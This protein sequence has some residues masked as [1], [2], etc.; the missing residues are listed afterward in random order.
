MSRKPSYAQLEQRLEKLEKERSMRSL[1]EKALG[2]N[3]KIVASAAIGI[4][5]YESSGECILANEMAAEFIGGTKEKLLRQNFR[6]I[7]SWKKTGLYDLAIETLSTGIT[8]TTEIT[9]T[10]TFGKK[11]SLHCRFGF[12]RRAP[13]LV[14]GF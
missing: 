8:R 13:G 9:T 10:S 6:H 12:L 5:V 4:T 11:V 1:S 7:Q 14:A 3:E 2:I